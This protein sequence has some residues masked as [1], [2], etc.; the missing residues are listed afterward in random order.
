M[1]NI[2]HQILVEYL[3]KREFKFVFQLCG[4]CIKKTAEHNNTQ[5][6][7]HSRY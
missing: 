6:F 4:V 7:S 5:N 3:K 1:T 2:K